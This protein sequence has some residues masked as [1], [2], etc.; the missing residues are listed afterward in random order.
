MKLHI[1]INHSHKDTVSVAITTPSGIGF[2][3]EAD[4]V[5]TALIQCYA[6][7]LNWMWNRKSI[8]PKL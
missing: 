7:V 8:T 4:D 3:S 2:H 6:K 1:E 5:K